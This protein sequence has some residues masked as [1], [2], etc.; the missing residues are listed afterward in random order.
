MVFARFQSDVDN[1]AS[2][3]PCKIST[4]LLK[5]QTCVEF[6]CCHISVLIN[7]ILII[8]NSIK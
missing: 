5:I 6:R 7:H 8:N 3:Q 2:D 4:K 1:G